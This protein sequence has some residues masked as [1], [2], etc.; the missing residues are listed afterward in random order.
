MSFWYEMQTLSNKGDVLTDPFCEKCG[1]K[2][3][4]LMLKYSSLHKYGTIDIFKGF[5]GSRKNL[6]N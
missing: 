5:I 4:Q 1:G 2:D 6:S 3:T